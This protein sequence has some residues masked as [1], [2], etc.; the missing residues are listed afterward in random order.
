M[1]DGC[2]ALSQ[3]GLEKSRKCIALVAGEA[4][5]DRLGAGLIGALR[6]RCPGLRF[7]GVA[8]PL[9]RDAGCEAWYQAEQLSVMG[10]AEVVRH[11]PRL[12][13]LRRSL[14]QQLH[15][16]APDCLV[17]I[18]A[19]DFNIPLEARMRRAGIPTVHYV[20]PSV[21]AW[22][23]GRVKKIRSS[24][25]LVLTLFPF[26]TEIYH[27]HGVQALCVGHPLA[28]ARTEKIDRPA[29]RAALGLEVDARLVGI[30]PGSRMG[31]V[32]R[33]LPVMLEA[34]RCLLREDANLQFALP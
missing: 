12:L 30:L 33:L 22:R 6:K 13:R 28:D 21:W 25:D 19:P 5:G 14:T 16:A 17:G 18:D 1:N 4:S 20:S 15:A 23:P 3:R 29:A 24:T 32:V 26:E 2:T 31:E 11:L 7:V 10:L 9:M 34:A 8:G 27:Q